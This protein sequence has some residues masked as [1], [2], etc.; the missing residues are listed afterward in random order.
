M[1][2]VATAKKVNADMFVSAEDQAILMQIRDNIRYNYFAVGDIANKYVVLCNSGSRFV[3]SQDIYDGVGAYIGKSGRT[4]RYY[5]EQ[6]AFYDNDTRDRYDILP[7]AFF[8]FARSMGDNWETILDYCM[9]NP[10]Y[11]LNSIRRKFLYEPERADIVDT[12][13]E[14]E[15]DE[16]ITVDRQSDERTVGL[17]L[18]VMMDLSA[19]ALSMAE[20]LDIS[21]EA[22]DTLRSAAMQI[23]EVLQGITK[24]SKL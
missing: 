9:D 13:E 11:N 16:I 1:I 3:L 4:V 15:I 22:K 17:F 8:V 6:A 18:S 19:R 24:N 23:R 10:H 14:T 21:K 2:E 5:A 20:T 12:P 7:F